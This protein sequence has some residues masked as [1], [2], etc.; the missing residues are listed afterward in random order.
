MT[1][2]NRP[3]VARSSQAAG[4]RVRMDSLR[5]TALVAGVL[6]LTTFAS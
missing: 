4:K 1:T 2:T 3:T 5:K 6:Y